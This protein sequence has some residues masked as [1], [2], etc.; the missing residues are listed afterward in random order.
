M[1]VTIKL[2][3]DA[4]GVDMDA[5]KSLLV[6]MNAVNASW[7]SAARRFGSIDACGQTLASG[8]ILSVEVSE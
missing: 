2:K 8:D 7:S 6:K 4:D 1:T 3:V 5:L